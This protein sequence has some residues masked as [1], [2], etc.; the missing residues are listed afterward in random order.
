ME[1]LNE[2]LMAVRIVMQCCI[3]ITIWA[4]VCFTFIG[5]LLSERAQ[6]QNVVRAALYSSTCVDS[7]PDTLDTLTAMII[8]FRVP[9]L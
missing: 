2:R 3:H 6:G 9:L 1:N 8:I 5:T 4:N 7:A